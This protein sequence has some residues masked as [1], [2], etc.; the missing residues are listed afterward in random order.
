MKNIITALANPTLNNKLKEMENIKLLFRDIQYQDAIFDIL[1]LNKN[2]TIDFLILS[3][4]LPGEINIQELISKIQKINFKIKIILILENRNEELENKLY[5]KGVFKIIYN[6]KTA[7]DEIIELINIEDKDINQ[8][9][10]N[11]IETL[12]KIIIE[13]QNNQ[14][15]NTKENKKNNL[16]YQKIKKI[17]K[18]KSKEIIK[19]EVISISGPS[20]S[21]K[22]IIS[23]NIAKSMINKVNKIL[24][25]DFDILNNSLHTILGVKKYPQ[26]TNKKIIES[27]IIKINKKID[28]LSV[29]EL[30]FQKENKVEIIEFINI[31]NKLKETYDI[32]IIDTSAECFFDYT[33]NIIKYSD[34][35]IFVIEANILEIK[36]AKNILNIYINKW[37]IDK[38]KFNILFNKYNEEAIHI[39]LLKQIFNEFNVIGTLRYDAKYNKLINKNIK[40]NLYNK[41]IRN[42][43]LEIQKKI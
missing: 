2:K 14:P 17:F 34:K 3:E 8:E 6:T 24:I 28:L 21:G 33:K 20:G 12:K 16:I 37:K 10:K 35:N 1:E 43:Y 13:N 25:I 42:E 7:I 39:K 31:I 36:K 22:S 9:L 19:K 26:K 32:I 30:L 38:D 40:H 15:K 27:F 29:T 23:V 5:N 11:E 18:N 41:K 4:H